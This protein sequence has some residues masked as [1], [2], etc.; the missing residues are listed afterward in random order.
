MSPRKAHIDAKDENPIYVELTSETRSTCGDV[1][2]K[3]NVDEKK[4]STHHR[5]PYPIL[6]L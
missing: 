1:D 5:L 3:I 6:L 4:T 2:D